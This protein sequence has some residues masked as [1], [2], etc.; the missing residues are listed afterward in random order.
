M[1]MYHELFDVAELLDVVVFFVTVGFTEPPG[2]CSII[3]A[4][5]IVEF[6]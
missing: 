5:G 3:T 1:L 6:L 4:S 2:R